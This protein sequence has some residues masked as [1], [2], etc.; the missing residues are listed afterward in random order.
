MDEFLEWLSNHAWVAWGGLALAFGIVETATVDLVFL[1]L[2]GGAVSGGI[3]ALA[4]GAVWLQITVAI[5]ASL[6]LLGVVRPIAKRHLKVPGRLRTGAAA[7]VGRQAVVV[8]EI[9]PSGGTI[10]LGGEIWT[11]RS[12]D[13]ETVLAPGTTVDVVEIQGA[14][15]MVFGVEELR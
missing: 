7:L 8:D 4:G 2:A 11:A 5:I 12:Y 15:A 1:M 9:S 14:T 6:A 10:K 3:V 13:G